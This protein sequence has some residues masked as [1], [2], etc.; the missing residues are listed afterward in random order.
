MKMP[1]DLTSKGRENGFIWDCI[2]QE[3]DV[4]TNQL[5][6]EWR[7]SDHF[8]PADMTIDGWSEWTGTEDDPYDWFHLNSVEKD[9]RGNYLVSARYLNGLTYIAGFTGDIIWNLGGKLGTFNDLTGGNATQMVDPQMAR[10]VDNGAAITVFDNIALW[11]FDSKQRQS[12]AVK[13][14]IGQQTREA[15]MM[16]EFVHPVA[17]FADG[18]GSMQQL[19]NGN[20]LMSYGTQSI[21]VEYSHAGELLCETAYGSPGATN[22]RKGTPSQTYR[23]YKQK[24]VGRPA[25]PPSVSILND[26]LF[27]SWN[28]ATELRSWEISSRRRR[29]SP[30]VRFAKVAKTGFETSI[31]LQGPTYGLE[32]Q[33][34][35]L[36]E[37]DEFLEAWVVQ[38]DGTLTVNLDET[39]VPGRGFKQADSLC[40]DLLSRLADGKVQAEIF[41]LVD[42][43]HQLLLSHII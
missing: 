30:W 35:A 13:I 4:S 8:T 22:A 14:G 21:Y 17:L 6:F 26:T 5:L 20:Y 27:V 28:G 3:L 31:P 38:Q 36:G 24:W 23:I 37:D 32:L 15:H 12:H 33:L 1:Y 40:T 10:W 41:C 18:E 16:Q 9:S 25:K 34:T 2:F 42:N 39:R 11:S 29:N 43:V 7:A 19:T